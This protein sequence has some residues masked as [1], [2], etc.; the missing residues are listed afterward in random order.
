LSGP[1]KFLLALEEFWLALLEDS[2][3]FLKAEAEILQQL[4]VF[5]EA[6]LMLV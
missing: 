1:K 2:S 6:T 5:L 3:D 4:A